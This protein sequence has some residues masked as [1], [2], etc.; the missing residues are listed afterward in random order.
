MNEVQK[1][2][3]KVKGLQ[4][5]A[6][7][8]K[9]L[10]VLLLIFV[11]ITPLAC[12]NINSPPKDRPSTEVNVGGEHGV[13]VERRNRPDNDSHDDRGDKSSHDEGEHGDR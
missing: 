9:V 4:M 1:D 13:T 7:V 12:L 10:S 8:K 5:V 2:G 6:I 11:A 3:I